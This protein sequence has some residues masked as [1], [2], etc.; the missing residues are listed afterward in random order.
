MQTIGTY[1][2]RVSAANIETVDDDVAIEE[3]L[4]MRLN[5]KPFS[6]TMR[7]PGHD[8][9]LAIGLLA[10]EGIIRSCEDIENVESKTNI[11]DITL[12]PDTT[13]D[14]KRIKRKSYT[15]S[16][17]GVCGKSS[18]DALQT[19]DCPLLPASSP[20]ISRNFIFSLSKSFRSAQQDFHRTGGVHAAA[21]FDLN[22]KLTC[23]REDVG[24]HNALDKVIGAQWRKGQLP[25]NDHV[26]MLSGRTSFE[27]MQKAFMAGIPIVAAHGAPSSLAIALAQRFNITLIGFMRAE[28]F[29]VYAGEHR[30]L[31]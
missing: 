29:N 25:L 20:L 28:S 17:C 30:L 27:L 8:I 7:T 5:G 10:C 19:T 22:G 6:V 11:I 3:P 14:E 26:L 2:T 18:L 15:T 1:V 4:E 31:Q 23:L 9:E 16:S 13:F 24:R 12:A 21:I